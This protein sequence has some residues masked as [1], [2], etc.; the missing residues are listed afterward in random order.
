MPRLLPCWR[1]TPPPWSVRCRWARLVKSEVAR[2]GVVK[3][4]RQGCASLGLEEGA[5]DAGF[6]EVVADW[7][8]H[9]ALHPGWLAF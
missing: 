8:G 9:S 5:A 2:G 6:G 1:S 7:L 4:R 3:V